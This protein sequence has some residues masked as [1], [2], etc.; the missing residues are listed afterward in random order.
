MSSVRKRHPLVVGAA[1]QLEASVRPQLLRDA[2]PV[3]RVEVHGAELR[4]FHDEHFF[5]GDQIDLPQVVNPRIAI[6]ERDQRLPRQLAAQSLESR[7]DAAN[8][9]QVDRCVRP[10]HRNLRA[11]RRPATCCCTIRRWPSA[12]HQRPNGCPCIEQRDSEFA[13]PDRPRVRPRPIASRPEPRCRRS[14][15]RQGSAQRPA[16]PRQRTE[17]GVGSE[18][19][20]APAGAEPRTTRQTTTAARRTLS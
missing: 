3:A 5:R 19:V 11:A 20:S 8:G 4:P 12:D 9:R 10:K 6:I 1:Q 14:A 15:R 13:L 2:R 16:G 17:R 18:V 7:T